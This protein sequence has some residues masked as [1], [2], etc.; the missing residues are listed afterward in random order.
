[1]I[2]KK[3]N[4][5]IKDI[6][7]RY[8]FKLFCYDATGTSI[9]EFNENAQRKL[10]EY[11]TN[12]SAKLTEYNSNHTSKLQEYNDNAQDKIDDYDE[13][14]QELND[15]IEY[16]KDEVND[17]SDNQLIAEEEGTEIY[18][19]D[20]ARARLNEFEMTKESS[21]VTTAGKNLYG[22]FIF[23]KVNSGITFNY[24]EDGTIDANGTATNT[25]RSMLSSEASQYLKRLNAGTYIISGG[26]G[27]ANIEVCNLNS[28]IATDTGNGAQFTLNEESDVFIRVKVASGKVLNNVKIYSMLS[29]SGGDYE[30]YTGGQPSPSPD[31]PQEVEVVEGYENLFN[32]GNV[33][34]ILGVLDDNGQPTGSTG[35]HYTDNYYN[36][37]SSTE[38]SLSGTLSNAGTTTR[39]YF[40][41]VNK[42]WI[43]RTGT[44]SGNFVNFVTPINCKYI[45][46]QVA[47]VI[48]L[49]TND[50]LLTPGN[51]LLPYVPYG[52]NYVDVKVTGKNLFNKNNVVDGYLLENGTIGVATSY[53]TSDYIPISPNTNYYKTR[54][55]SPRCKYYDINKQP[56]NT[57][58]YQDIDIGTHEGTFITPANAYYVRLSIYPQTI[59][60]NDVQLEKGSVAT[61]YESFK[62][63]IVPIA[64]NDNFIGGKGDYLDELIVDKFGKCYLNKVFNKVV[65]DGVNN[66]FTGVGSTNTTDVHRFMTADIGSKLS[67]SS[68]QVI[69]A[70]CNRLISK[71]LDDTYVKREGFS[72]SNSTHKISIYIDEISTYTLEQANEWL[73]THNLELYY[74]LAQED[75]IDLHYTID[76]KTFKGVSNINNSE[77]AN[78]KIRYVQD[79]NTII[80]NINNAILEIGGGN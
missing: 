33:E 39:I 52:N 73:L 54:T 70:F 66:L 23:N 17:L 62:E 79:I 1:M 25:A 55:G 9:P 29:V 20:S 74:P 49:A 21:Q 35:S 77:N 24:N 8:K 68:T 53:K 71:S 28:T 65:L 75:L 10:N 67:T 50:V 22:G 58:T 51:K 80:A 57:T 37:N 12:A 40:Y 4:V 13:H 69:P 61:S 18:V 11:N 27:D 14:V 16:L 3:Y 41:D 78:M 2:S 56:L 60:L 15:E 72:F 48:T 44:L 32:Q 42:N 45:R 5:S 19:T 36:V 47:N 76:L 26:T 46:I 7:N 34:F 38:Y 64:L 30:P 43:S 59:S 31:Y 6:Q 63:S